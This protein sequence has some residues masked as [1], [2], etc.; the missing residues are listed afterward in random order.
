MTNLRVLSQAMGGN[1]VISEFLRP[2]CEKLG[3]HFQTMSEW[4]K[5]G[6][7]VHDILWKRESWLSEIEKSDIV[8]CVSRH[9]EQPA[10]SANRAVQAMALG[11]PV[12]AS[13]LPAYLEVIKEGENGYI[14]R[15]ERDW[16]KALE[17]LAS[18]A[19]LRK[20]MGDAARKAAQ[21]FSMDEVG[22]K[23]VDF[24]KGR[25]DKNCVPPSCDVIIPTL[26]NLSYLKPC[27]ESIRTATDWPHR[28]VVV[29]SGSKPETLKWI[30]EQPD[31]QLV[32]STTKLHFSAANNAGLKASS[33]P[34]VC[35]LNDDT[36][37]GKGWLNALMHEAMKPGMGAVGPF[38][39]CDRGWL[40]DEAIVVEGHA[41]VPDMRV[42]ALEAILPKI[43]EYRHRKV[44]T[45]RKWVAFYCT[46]IPRAAIEKVGLLDEG[47]L[48][49]DEDVD[50]SKR[51]RDAGYRIVQT[52]DSWVFHFGG[53]TRKQS[54]QADPERHRREDEANHAYFKKK[55]G[56]Y[57]GISSSGTRLSRPRGFGE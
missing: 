23:W 13:P 30:Q 32:H 19:E 9:E 3:L 53:K 8:V 26:D 27:I 43:Q 50:Y 49:G 48:S 52:W 35:L 36:I 22:K 15:S 33:S 2:I 45:E 1:V 42:E 11:K 56:I 14:C 41:L 40:H 7:P 18:D 5:D 37:V 39:N 54:D 51:L 44:V 38:S 57:P 20:K 46:L 21:P 29:Y 31:V 12:L 16:E 24:L 17:R 25:A 6:A 55:W 34:Y 4:E 47:F 10:K 28:I